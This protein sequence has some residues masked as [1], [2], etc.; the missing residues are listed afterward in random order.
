MAEHRHHRRGWAGLRH[1]LGHLLK[2]HTHDTPERVDA[3]LEASADGLRTLWVSLL[4][5]GLTAA[6]QAVAVARSGSVALVGAAGSGAGPRYADPVVGLPITV[7]IPAALRGSLREAGRRLVDAV[8][9]APVD[10]AERELR[11]VAGVRGAGAVRMRWVGH[12][13]RAE[14]EVVVDPDLTARHSGFGAGSGTPATVA[15]RPPRPQAAGSGNCPAALPVRP[16]VRPAGAG[17]ARWRC[18]V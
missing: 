4:V 17:P 7:A 11:A 8:D 15:G 6:V 5:L 2:P 13:L 9:P 3:A 14:A 10:A 1:R 16:P 12:A 18:E